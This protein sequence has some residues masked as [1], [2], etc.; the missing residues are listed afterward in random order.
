MHKKIKIY[1]NYVLLN[2]KKIE[3]LK[4]FKYIKYDNKS[5]ITK[6]LLTN[7]IK[8]IILLFILCTFKINFYYNKYYNNI[9]SFFYENN[10]DYSN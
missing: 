1:Q 10:I 8:N 6:N 3:F 5:N 4:L 9:N 7:F 2:L